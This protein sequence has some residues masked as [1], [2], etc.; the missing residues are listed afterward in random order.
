MGEDHARENAAISDAMTGIRRTLRLAAIAALVAI[1]NIASAAEPYP[2]RPI[3]FVVGFAAGGPTDII[4]RR[5]AQTLSERLGQ[6]VI[7]ENKPGAGGNIA[8]EY[9]INA[10]PDGY[11]ILVVATANAIN[12]TFYQKLSF[13]FLRDIV[14]VAGLAR[15]SYVM[16][17]SPSVPAKTVAE[18]IA[19]AR[20]NPGK[21]NF[22]SGGAGGSNHLAGEMF[23]GMTG[24]DIVHVPYRGNAGAY[25]DLIAGEVQLIFADIGSSRPHIQSGALRALAV[26]STTRSAAFPDLPTVAETVPGYEASAWYGF[27]VPKGTP[28]EIVERL[29][30]EINAAFDHPSLK[31]AFS[32]LEAEPMVFTP[33][34]FAA[35]MAS[36]AERWGKAVRA[37]GV[38]GD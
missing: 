5:M 16:A 30:R 8:T 23:K 34:E 12:T 13:N 21:V 2:T 31:V 10:P 15:I 18:F 36:E 25:S 27:G 24:I 14:P 1:P 11:T 19:Y 9:V 28:A 7:V 35:F 4:A 38:K 6:Q 32:G 29:N 20:A 3:R 37:S 17:V 26:T 33:A 22:A